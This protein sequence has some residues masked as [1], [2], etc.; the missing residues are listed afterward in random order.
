[1]N[2][3]FGDVVEIILEFDRKVYF[4]K[5]C[6]GFFFGRGFIKE[7]FGFFWMCLR[8]LLK[9][10][11]RLKFLKLFLEVEFDKFLEM[12]IFLFVLLVV[13]MEVCFFLFEIVV[14]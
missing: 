1:M 10:R 14:D 4:W 8:M 13:I 2:I 11:L 9:E 5:V 12:I 6:L 7:V 3:F